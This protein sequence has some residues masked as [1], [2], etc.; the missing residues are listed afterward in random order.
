[1]TRPEF[2]FTRKAV[3]ISPELYDKLSELINGR[4]ATLN[5]RKTKW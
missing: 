3:G 2:L 4:G 1:M 5:G